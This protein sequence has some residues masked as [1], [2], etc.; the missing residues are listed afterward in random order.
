MPATVEAAA[1]ER[2]PPSPVA[3]PKHIFSPGRRPGSVDASLGQR[4]VSWMSQAPTNGKI[5]GLGW[6]AVGGM[7]GQWLA[8]AHRSRVCRLLMAEFEWALSGGARRHGAH[9]RAHP[10]I[11]VA[12][13]QNGRA[14]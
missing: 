4:F 12:G 8:H 10:R 1:P 7:L 11:R 9:G 3:A 2:P 6:R 5:Q 13:H 14:V